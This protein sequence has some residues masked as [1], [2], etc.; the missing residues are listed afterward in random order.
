MYIGNWRCQGAYE[1]LDKSCTACK[2]G[3]DLDTTNLPTCPCNSGYFDDGAACS[4]YS[5][6]KLQL[7]TLYIYI[8]MIIISSVYYCWELE[9]SSL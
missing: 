6:L 7:H 2:T 1:E 8:L 5:Y 9:M 3:V 4:T